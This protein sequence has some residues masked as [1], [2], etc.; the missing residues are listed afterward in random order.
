[1]S[2]VKQIIIISFSTICYLLIY[3]CR[4]CCVHFLLEVKPISNHSS[5][6]IE[7][8]LP[9]AKFECFINDCDEKIGKITIYYHSSAHDCIAG[10]IHIPFYLKKQN[11]TLNGA[12]MNYRITSADNLYLLMLSFSNL[13]SMFISIRSI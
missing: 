5:T 8:V 11:S 3:D 12:K 4:M 7:R 13:M 6:L 9:Y 10:T 1:M 2:F